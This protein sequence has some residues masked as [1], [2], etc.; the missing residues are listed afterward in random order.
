MP[1]VHIAEQEALL[2][3][4]HV[5]IP[6]TVRGTK[7]ELRM[8]NGETLSAEAICS[9][10]D[11]F[12]RRVGRKLAASRLLSRMR[13]TRKFSAVERERVFKSICPEYK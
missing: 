11:Q 5:G 1:K 7:V 9:A 6:G 8:E 13:D 3:V 2:R 4:R 10:N 12:N